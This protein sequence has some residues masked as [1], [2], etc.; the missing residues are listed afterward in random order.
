MHLGDVNND[1]NPKTSKKKL[2]KNKQISF[3]DALCATPFDVNDANQDNTSIAGSVNA[4]DAGKSSTL[5]IACLAYR[6]K[7]T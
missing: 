1:A 3:L 5:K 7:N 2:K 6:L 4:N